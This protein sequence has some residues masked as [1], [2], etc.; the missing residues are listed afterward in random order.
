MS[1]SATV[2]YV[3]A[4][5]DHVVRPVTFVAVDFPS[6]VA[7][8]CTTPYPFPWGGYTWGGFGDLL[9][10]DT[11]EEDAA[12]S[13]PLAR[14]GLSGLDTDLVTQAL[15]ENYR[16][17][18]MQIWHG[19]AD[20]DGDIIADPVLAWEGMVDTCVAE[21]A[22][23]ASITLTGTHYLDLVFRTRGGRY[24]NA[25]QQAR[26]PG[27]KF[28]EFLERMQTATIVWGYHL[29]ANRNNPLRDA[30]LNGYVTNGGTDVG[31]RGYG[32]PASAGGRDQAL[33]GYR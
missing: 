28:F 3:A 6:G 13:A 24:N 23:T 5:T 1:R 26:Y 20:S 11:I 14:V 12:L 2:A 9:S 7:R 19:V 21:F 17:R 33:R 29:D 4:L 15:T 10:I 18:A 8:L 30:A 31:T 25:D 16:N 32:T 27:D 22:D